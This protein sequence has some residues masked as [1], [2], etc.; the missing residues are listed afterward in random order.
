MAAVDGREIGCAGQIGGAQLAIHQIGIDL[1]GELCTVSA[2]F[3]RLILS[4]RAFCGTCS[5]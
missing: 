3:T 4:M 1:A 2:P 5:V